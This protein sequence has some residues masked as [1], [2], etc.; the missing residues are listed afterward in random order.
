MLDGIRPIRAVDRQLPGGALVRA[1]ATPNSK[2]AMLQDWIKGRRSEV[3]EM[4]G[5]VVSE[6][7]RAGVPVPANA[8]VL[9]ISL[10]IEAG[11]VRFVLC[12][13]R[14]RPRAGLVI[15]DDAVFDAAQARVD[16]ALEFVRAEGISAI[17]EVGDPDRGYALAAPGAIGIAL[18]FRASHVLKSCSDGF[19]DLAMA[20]LRAP[21]KYSSKSR[22]N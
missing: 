7:K 22:L 16:L 14:T 3:H 1:S 12:V 10:R 18:L 5:Y 13:P 11:D 4:N 20:R 8:R 15:Y 21:Q 9:D 17:G 19:S 2:V 6:G